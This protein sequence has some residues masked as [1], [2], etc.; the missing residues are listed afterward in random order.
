[1][2]LID[3]QFQFTLLEF[4]NILLA[5]CATTRWHYRSN[6]RHRTLLWAHSWEPFKAHTFSGYIYLW[7]TAESF[8]AISIQDTNINMFLTGIQFI[9]VHLWASLYY[10]FEH[11]NTYRL[12]TN[13][14][15]YISSKHIVHIYWYIKE[16]ENS[17][18]MPEINYK[19]SFYQ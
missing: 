18:Q 13:A 14:V 10:I 19:S 2:A 17:H 1:M 11:F 4:C 3:L 16:S 9:V 6:T 7:L 8:T 12:P 5:V 15:N